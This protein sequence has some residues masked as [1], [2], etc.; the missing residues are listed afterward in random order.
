MLLLVVVLC[1]VS[2][3]AVAIRVRRRFDSEEVLLAAAIFVGLGAAA[4]VVAGWGKPDF[5]YGPMF[6]TLIGG[7]AA[8]AGA[9][10]YLASRSPDPDVPLMHALAVM[11]FGG[12]A[13]IGFNVGYMF[14]AMGL[15][16]SH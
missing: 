8:G 1:A 10:N 16:W 6:G 15:G 11:A 4:I 12:G 2:F 3:V 7:T 9:V 14:S 13:N 5:L